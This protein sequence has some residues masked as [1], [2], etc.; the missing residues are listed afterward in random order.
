VIDATRLVAEARHTTGLDDLG[1]PSWTEGLDRLVDSLQTDAQLNEMGEIILSAQVKR[2]LVTRLE[3]EHWHL[4]HPHLA[5]RPVTGPVFIVGLPRTGTTLLSYL[6]DAD[7]AN[8]SLLRGEAFAA[9]PPLTTA[10]LRSD[11]RIGRADAEQEGLYQA[12]PAFKAIHHETGAGPTECIT[13]LGQ[14]FRSAHWETMANI[15]RYG[16]WHLACDMEPAYRWH[17]RVLQVLQSD[18]PGRWCLKSPMHNLALESLVAVYPDARFIVTHRDPAVVLASLCR[19]VSIL[20]GLGTDHDFD[21]YIGQ[22]WLEL[23]RRLVDR[24]LGFRGWAG[25][26]T[27][28]SN[29]P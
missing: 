29:R 3:V 26:S 17:R 19:L 15:P 6:L 5:D 24:A 27:T 14:D 7:P 18:A 2:S 8:R 9:V 4:T 23:T 13:L 1:A 22:R 16:D 12:A 28:R 21:A 20:S 25:P 10:T 11:P